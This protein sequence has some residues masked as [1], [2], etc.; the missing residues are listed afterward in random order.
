M[1]VLIVLFGF[2]ASYGVIQ[3]R[4]YWRRRRVHRTSVEELAARIRP[5]DMDLISEIA[6]NFLNPSQLRLRL[7]PPTMWRDLGEEKGLAVL[8]ANADAML[9]LATIASKW[10][11]VE[12]RIIAE[13]VRRDGV[14]LKR[15]VWKIRVAT[16]FGFCEVFAPFQLQEAAAAYYLM[17]TRLLTLYEGAPF[18][19]SFP[20]AAAL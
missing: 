15:A 19:I 6:A 4:F 7:E 20:L 1:L 10:D 5:V 17:R 14:R 12:G 18:G 16:L 8:A 3:G 13:M 9:D 11:Q 2:L